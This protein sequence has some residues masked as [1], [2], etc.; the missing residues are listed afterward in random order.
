LKATL[1]ASTPRSQ[2]RPKDVDS[3]QG[4]DSNQEAN[5]AS[6]DVDSNH[7][8]ES[9]QEA[10]SNQGAKANRGAESNQGAKANQ[11]A[12]VNQGAK[13]NQDDKV[14]VKDIECAVKWLEHLY[15]PSEASK[16]STKRLYQV[17]K[18]FIYLID[19]GGFCDTWRESQWGYDFMGSV[20]TVVEALKHANNFGDQVEDDEEQVVLQKL[21]D[22]GV[23]DV[24]DD[25]SDQVN[26]LL[27]SLEANAG[28]AESKTYLQKLVA[29]KQPLFATNVARLFGS[30]YL[31]RH[32]IVYDRGSHHGLRTTLLPKD[33]LDDA[34]EALKEAQDLGIHSLKSLYD[35][36]ETD[37]E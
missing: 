33:V 30:L 5:M 1:K 31:L 18:H 14:L 10:E 4:A 21:Y 12:E 25:A 35:F 22:E 7:E 28:M 13:S 9:N 29:R 36:W 20:D 27:E 2:G 8:G 26:E 32:L 34:K 24:Y 19:V 15:E 17:C 11:E 6:Q 3:N 16:A 37:S 23:E